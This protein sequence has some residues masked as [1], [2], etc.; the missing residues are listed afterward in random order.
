MTCYSKFRKITHFVQMNSYSENFCK[1]VLRDL[2][3]EISIASRI[4]IATEPLVFWCFQWVKNENIGQKCDHENLGLLHL[5]GTWWILKIIQSYSQLQRTVT[6][7]R[8]SR[9]Q[10]FCRTA[11]CSNTFRRIRRKASAIE[12]YF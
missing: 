12:S 5:R 6:N 10:I 11:S 8:R 2:F 1:I 4:S 3:L 7:F 9:P